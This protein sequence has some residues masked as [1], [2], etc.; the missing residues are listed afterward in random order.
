MQR[1]TK[2][3]ITI[4]KMAIPLLFTCGLMLGGCG[5]DDSGQT[6]RPAP[7][8]S[9]FT[10]EPQPLDLTSELPG[11]TN[12]FQLA[13]IRPQVNGIIQKV[14]FTE[15]SDVTE[16]SLLFQIDPILYQA[17]FNSARASLAK[18]EA[19]LPSIQSRA[20]RYKELLKINA[21]SQ[22]DYD[23]TVSSLAQAK[24]DLA[25]AKAALETA[26]TNLA[27]TRI[28]APFSGRIGKTD[29]R[30]GTL[31]TAYQAQSLATLQQLN[32][33]YV[34]VTQSSVDFLRLRKHYESGA[35][36]ENAAISRKVTLLLEDGTAYP[37]T[38]SLQFLDATVDPSTGSFFIRIEIPNPDLVLYP[39]MF[40]RAILQEGRAPEAILV[41]QQ[42]IKRN[43]RGEP[44]AFLITPENVIREVPVV[45][46]RTIGNQW[47][48]SSGLSK[49]DRIVMEGS[50]NIRE[51]STVRAVPF[52]EK[53]EEGQNGSDAPKDAARK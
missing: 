52:T 10:V 39:G 13:E 6:K 1:E 32:P 23:D 5:S 18:A 29:A 33:I 2:K 53:K 14:A 19:Y 31:V 42:A 8:V 30:I 12:V 48:I 37:H 43:H 34:D 44:Y 15:G 35:L 24:A 25:Y 20:D 21:V 47:L 26:A 46:D 17:A 41:P 27:Y 50:L 4:L 38:G 3:H 11:R 22:Q 9:F 16:G 49:G 51:G 40:V 7:E 28:T 36:R 45:L